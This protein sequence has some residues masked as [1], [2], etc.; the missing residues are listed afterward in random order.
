MSNRR[1][2]L[3]TAKVVLSAVIGF[4]VDLF[5]LQDSL[6]SADCPAIVRQSVCLSYALV[7]ARAQRKRV[8]ILVPRFALAPRPGYGL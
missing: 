6:L 7:L 3:R 2:K 8:E 4:R 5:S 1:L